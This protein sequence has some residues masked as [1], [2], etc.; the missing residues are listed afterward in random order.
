MS[1]E[2]IAGELAL[3][4]VVFA[5]TNEIIRVTGTKNEIIVKLYE[6]A[7]VVDLNY[8]EARVPSEMI[9]MIGVLLVDLLQFNLLKLFGVL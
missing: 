2:H 1:Y 9:S 7:A 4:A 3:H 8:D 5:V 6:K